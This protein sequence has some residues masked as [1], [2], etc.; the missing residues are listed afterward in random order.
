M[1]SMRPPMF[2]NGEPVP[3]SFTYA[4]KSVPGGYVTLLREFATI[5]QWKKSLMLK[6]SMLD[7]SLGAG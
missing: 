1:G 3:E 6:Q 4:D 7:E 5:E 2:V